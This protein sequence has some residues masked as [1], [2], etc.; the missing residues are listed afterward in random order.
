MSP[1]KQA[2]LIF[3]AQTREKYAQYKN[4]PRTWVLKDADL[5]DLANL[6]PE[7]LDDLKALDV[8]SG[9]IKHNANDIVNFVR[10]VDDDVE[11]FWSLYQPLSSEQKQFV[12]QVSSLI[13]H[14]SEDAGISRSLIANRKDIE[15][16][17]RNQGAKFQFGWRANLFENYELPVFS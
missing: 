13:S 12:K 16:Y 3:L 10:E 14:V 17:A 8:K 7:S 2:L 6:F 5:Y 11:P 1:P 4:I 15:S 9:F